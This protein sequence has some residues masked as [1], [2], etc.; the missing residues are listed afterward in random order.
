MT[1]VVFDGFVAFFTFSPVASSAGLAA[2]VVGGVTTVDG[3]WITSLYLNKSI[4]Q[5]EGILVVKHSLEM[6]RK[7]T[8]TM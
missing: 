4:V 8:L 7:F 6:I 1:F 5:A 2:S 3:T